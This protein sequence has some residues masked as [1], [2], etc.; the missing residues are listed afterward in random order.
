[1]VKA[2]LPSLQW[3]TE[4]IQQYMIHLKNAN[5]A[6]LRTFLRVCIFLY[7]K[8][9]HN[10][11]SFLLISYSLNMNSRIIS[12]PFV[13]TARTLKQDGRQSNKEHSKWIFL[14]VNVHWGWCVCVC[15]CVF[16]RRQI[17][18]EYLSLWFC[19]VNS[20]CTPPTHTLGIFV[21][22]FSSP[23]TITSVCERYMA[24]KPGAPLETFYFTSECVAEGHPGKWGSSFLQLP[25]K[26]DTIAF[27]HY[28]L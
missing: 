11:I 16:F 14:Y 17:K 10:T 12:S 27:F 26:N 1:M 22:L 20:T 28:F 3:S 6:E 13:P 8:Q 2:F 7:T 4:L 18:Y 23:I 5:V 19:V 24:N 25:D 9:H 21:A 15:V